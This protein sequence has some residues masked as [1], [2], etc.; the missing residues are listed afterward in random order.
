M[1]NFVAYDRKSARHNWQ[2]MVMT[3]SREHVECVMTSQKRMAE[4]S[5]GWEGYEQY[6]T[7]F[8]GS[9]QPWTLPKNHKWN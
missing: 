8:D 9:Q 6:L 1:E 3:S 5:A 7:T 4:Q 2:L